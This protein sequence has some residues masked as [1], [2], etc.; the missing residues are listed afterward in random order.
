MERYTYFEG[1]KW[2]L[3][4]GD[5]E[6]SGPWVDR[7]AAYEDTGLEPEDVIEQKEMVQ[8]YQKMQDSK[9]DALLKS[10]D[11]TISGIK[12][13]E[14]LAVIGLT[15]ADLPRAAELMQADRDGRYVVLPC[16]VGDTIYFTK[17]AFLH[18]K[19]PIPATVW[20]ILCGVTDA[21][22]CTFRCMSDRGEERAFTCDN[23]GKT[24]FLTRAE[25][26]AALEDKQ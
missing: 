25:A 3:C 11:N 1:G 12:D 19:E 10:L 18:A 2:R 6:H 5:T 9:M 17:Q 22:F 4:A 13:R 8:F 26:E 24:V 16:K 14:E 7:L 15:P 21:R 23:I 20:T